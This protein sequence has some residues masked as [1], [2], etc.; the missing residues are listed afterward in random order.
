MPRRRTAR[1]QAIKGNTDYLAL[2][3]GRNQSAR[4][5]ARAV[6]SLAKVWQR[7][8]QGAFYRG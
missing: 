1:T 8:E 5:S 3:D 7:Q 2:P 6:N 4:C